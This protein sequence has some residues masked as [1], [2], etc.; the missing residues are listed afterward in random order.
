MFSMFN[1]FYMKSQ[2]RFS[3]FDFIINSECAMS[4]STSNILHYFQ[5]KIRTSNTI[6]LILFCQIVSVTLAAV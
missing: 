4:C 1:S 6:L 2:R 5:M 3:G